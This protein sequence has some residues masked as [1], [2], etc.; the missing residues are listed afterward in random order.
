M[1]RECNLISPIFFC[2][3]FHLFW[4]DLQQL[5]D[6]SAVFL[7]IKLQPQDVW[8]PLLL[9]VAVVP[10]KLVEMQ[11]Q[12]HMLGK[13]GFNRSNQIR[14]HK[15]KCAQCLCKYPQVQSEKHGIVLGLSQYLL[16]LANTCPRNNYFIVILTQLYATDIVVNTLLKSKSISFSRIVRSIRMW[17]KYKW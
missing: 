6:R 12:Q 10:G 7:S 14:F 2:F 4:I 17:K 9:G 8:V 11:T 1:I 3:L 5:V 16:L 15:G 13:H